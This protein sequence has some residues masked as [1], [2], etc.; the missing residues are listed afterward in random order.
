MTA[1]AG[2]SGFGLVDTFPRRVDD[3]R[4][5]PDEQAPHGVAD[6]RLRRL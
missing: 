6:G 1:R 5:R 2:V 3:D 4:L